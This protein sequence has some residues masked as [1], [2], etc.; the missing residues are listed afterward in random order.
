MSDEEYE[1][2]ANKEEEEEE[3]QQYEDYGSEEG[4]EGEEELKDHSH[5]VDDNDDEED[6]EDQVVLEEAQEEE[7]V[8]DIRDDDGDDGSI[9][10]DG[11]DDPEGHVDN[12]G[13]QEEEQQQGSG[14]SLDGSM[15]QL[16]IGNSSMDD[17]GSTVPTTTTATT[18]APSEEPATE[19]EES[20][21]SI[22][23]EE[24]VNFSDSF[25]RAI[26]HDY[27]P[28]GE[29]KL[30]QPTNIPAYVVGNEAS[31]KCILIFSDAIGIHNGR[32]KLIADEFA[33]LCGYYVVMPDF[34]GDDPPLIHEDEDM[35]VG[36]LSK[37]KS[38]YKYSDVEHHIVDSIYP[39]C[40]GG[41]GKDARKLYALG[42]GY[43]AYLWTYAA[44][45]PK[46]R[47]TACASPHPDIVKISD[48]V[49]DNYK[50]AFKKYRC[51]ILLINSENDPKQ[52]KAEGKISNILFD[53]P[54][55]PASEFHTQFDV[56]TK[57][58]IRGDVSDD[59]LREAMEAVYE[60]FVRFFE[61]YT[62]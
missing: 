49:G 9:G 40:R 42:F 55:L 46:L 5:E 18:S 32:H 4:F 20:R 38:K 23:R 22:V 26:T 43:G 16:D 25:A 15:D 24:I 13:E 59:L 17:I 12:E 14:A 10:K 52:Q 58:S 57:W 36:F 1:V 28:G 3:E 51:P 30:L 62:E 8:E 54:G 33:N 37:I 48:A 6:D 61:R 47:F 29:I 27:T 45:N 35:S 11:N 34:F 44:A 56:Q 39:F 7:D 60:N 19:E 21:G 53:I 50:K 2:D 41:L 31:R